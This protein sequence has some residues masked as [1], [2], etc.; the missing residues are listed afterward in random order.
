MEVNYAYD[1]LAEVDTKKLKKAL[2]GYRLVKKNFAKKRR[3]LPDATLEAIHR[4][5]GELLSRKE[6]ILK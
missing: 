5:E 4:I 2:G 3:N 1:S 6:I